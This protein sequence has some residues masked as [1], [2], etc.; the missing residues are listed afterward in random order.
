[1]FTLKLRYYP[2]I[3]EIYNWFHLLFWCSVAQ[4]QVGFFKPMQTESIATT[5]FNTVTELPK[6][7]HLKCEKTFLLTVLLPSHLLSLA[8]SLPLC[9]WRGS[10]PYLELIVGVSNIISWLLAAVN[11]SI[12]INIHSLTHKTFWSLNPP[13]PAQVSTGFFCSI[14]LWYIFEFCVTERMLLSCTTTTVRPILVHLSKVTS[15]A[16]RFYIRMC[17]NEIIYA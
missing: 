5:P 2:K 12:N 8:L 3:L 13:H 10:E 16:L 6:H 7:T 4:L 14:F 15:G 17:Y 1:M 9:S 11:K